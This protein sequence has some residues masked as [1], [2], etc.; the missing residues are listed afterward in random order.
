LFKRA[1]FFS[2]FSAPLRFKNQLP[3]A[4]VLQRRRKDDVVGGFRRVVIVIGG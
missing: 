1:A 2:V 4:P 3:A